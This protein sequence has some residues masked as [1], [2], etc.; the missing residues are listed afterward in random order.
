[1]MYPFM[2]LD[3][4]TEIVH[5]EYLD[6]G[7]VKVYAETPDEEKGFLHM[8]VFLP[9]Y[10]IEEIY[11]YDEGMKEK[12]MRV[13]DARSDEIIEKWLSFFGRIDYYC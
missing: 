7:E 13:I 8:T 1:M 6:N 2:T 3:D 5:S 4:G 12:I 11:G 10:R 9:S